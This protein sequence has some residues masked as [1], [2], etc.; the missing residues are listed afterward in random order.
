MYISVVVVVT[1]TAGSLT[2]RYRI[3]K[4]TIRTSYS[5][6]IFR[7]IHVTSLYVILRKEYTICLIRSCRTGY[8]AINVVALS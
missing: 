2:E 7:K 5:A 6:G 1:N 8:Y 4:A 3:R